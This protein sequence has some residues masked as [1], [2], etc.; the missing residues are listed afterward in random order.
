MK[1]E[2][3]AMMKMELVGGPLDGHVAVCPVMQ[4]PLAMHVFGNRHADGTKQASAYA[5]TNRL[6]S[7]GALVLIFIMVVGKGVKTKN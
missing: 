7:D 1:V 5:Q 4:E 2:V 6:K 3:G